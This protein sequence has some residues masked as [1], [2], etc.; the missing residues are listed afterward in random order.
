MGLMGL[1]AGAGSRPASA[2]PRLSTVLR[3]GVCWWVPALLVAA[4][5]FEPGPAT[6]RVFSLIGLVSY[7]VYLLHQPMGHLVQALM[8]RRVHVPRDWSGL[9][10]G[11][12]FLAVVMGFAW[13][14]DGHY[15]APVRRMLRA[16]FMPDKPKA[17]TVEA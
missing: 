2:L 14:L 17:V 7:A 1:R 3:V 12:V 15:D 11:A 10:F 16:R 13:W 9:I 6:G 5:H 8:G 4:A